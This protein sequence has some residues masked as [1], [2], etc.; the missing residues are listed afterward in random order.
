MFVK[1]SFQLNLKWDLD[2]K[3]SHCSNEQCAVEGEVNRNTNNNNHSNNNSTTNCEV[4]LTTGDQHKSGQNVC[5]M[6]Q[7]NGEPRTTD[8]P[9]QK[10]QNK[11]QRVNGQHEPKHDVNDNFQNVDS[12]KT[13]LNQDH[14]GTSKRSVRNLC[15]KEDRRNASVLS[16]TAYEHKYGNGHMDYNC[17][18]SLN[19]PKER[20]GVSRFDSA[21]QSNSCEGEKKASKYFCDFKLDKPK[22]S[23]KENQLIKR[24]P[25]R[26]L[27][28]EL[29]VHIVFV[30]CMINLW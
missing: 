29:I 16:N 7:I 14:L 28:T 19:I 3:V 30:Y 15:K 11:E 24:M 25:V 2:P 13:G 8:T 5:M 27:A 21:S 26:H 22:V 18:D 12:N 20:N 6:C 17:N 1:A 23:E 4:T 10:C 9:C